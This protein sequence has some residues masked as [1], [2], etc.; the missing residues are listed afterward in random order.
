MQYVL[1]FTVNFNLA[2]HCCLVATVLVCKSFKG[3]MINTG[4]SVNERLRTNEILAYECFLVLILLLRLQLCK[5]GILLVIYLSRFESSLNGQEKQQDCKRTLQD[6]A[7]EELVGEDP[8]HAAHHHCGQHDCRQ[9]VINYH[10]VLFRMFV[11]QGV[12]VASY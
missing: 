12:E 4:A 8:Y 6:Y 9:T 2:R 3:C 11:V 5:L 7:G 1:L 10:S